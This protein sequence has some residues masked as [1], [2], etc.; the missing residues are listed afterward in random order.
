MSIEKFIS[1]EESARR[2]ILSAMHKVIISVDEKVIPE[3]SKM[4]GQEMLV[5][6]CNG[7]MKY[8]LA[9]GKAHM[10][11]HVLPMYGSIKIHEKFKKLLD[12]AK[13]QKGCINFKA[14]DEMPLKIVGQLIKD[15]AP[16]DLASMFN[17][18]PEERRAS[19]E[20]IDYH[21]KKSP[22]RKK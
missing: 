15:C 19:K 7:I 10:S 5:Y 20:W 18:K 1:K 8:A 21:K 12:K 17:K 6:K 3:V 22:P 4:M 14:A 11:L 9:S 13:F 16:I 2:E